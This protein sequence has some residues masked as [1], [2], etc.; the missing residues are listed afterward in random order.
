MGRSSR[1]SRKLA[2]LAGFVLVALLT[3][4]ARAAGQEVFESLVQDIREREYADVREHLVMAAEQMPVDHYSFRFGEGLRSFGEELL[5]A[6]AVNL[7]LCGLAGDRA[8][9]STGRVSTP[10][11]S[12][13]EAVL[14]TLRRSLTL[15]DAV[16]EEITDDETLEPTFGRYIRG[17]HLIAMVGHCNHV[18]GK[19]TL[20]MRVNGQMPPSSG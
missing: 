7:R 15:C 10:L 12:D 20:M 9:P 17:S 3:P 5:H 11:G 4:P 16:L 8:P 18:Y 14:D 6:A 13:K 19:L 2:T 1:W